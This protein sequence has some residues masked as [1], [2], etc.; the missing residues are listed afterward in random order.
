[1]LIDKQFERLTT[2]AQYKNKV[3]PLKYTC[4]LL[5]GIFASVWFFFIFVQMF[6]AG[7]L[8]FEGR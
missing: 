1:M 2:I 8:T 6:V 3:E 7:S 4:H 5:F